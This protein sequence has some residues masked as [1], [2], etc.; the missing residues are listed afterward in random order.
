MIDTHAKTQ[1]LQALAFA[2]AYPNV[3]G[4][5][6]GTPAMT[7]TGDDGE[8]VEIPACGDPDYYYISIRSE[9]APVLPEGVEAVAA[10]ETTAVLGVWA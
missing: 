7:L 4:P 10:A 1:N 5:R 2:A 8:A 9:T 3:L 6:A